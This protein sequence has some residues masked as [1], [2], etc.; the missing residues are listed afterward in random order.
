MFEVALNNS[1]A[2]FKVLA[3]IAEQ[4]E[5]R[6]SSKC[7][8]RERK[9]IIINEGLW[10]CFGWCQQPDT[11][12]DDEDYATKTCC[13]ASFDGAEKKEW[14][15]I[16]EK[17]SFAKDFNLL[18]KIR[19]MQKRDVKIDYYSKVHFNLNCVVCFFFN[20]WRSIWHFGWHVNYLMKM[21]LTLHVR[22]YRISLKTLSFGLEKRGQD[23][24]FLFFPFREIVSYFPQYFRVK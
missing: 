8:G 2:L 9:V 16:N 22:K 14:Y 3:G 20:F 23:F 12:D 1:E 21:K 15:Y 17:E 10:R 11:E 7:L 4:D 13:A 6:R 24:F 5:V 19:K 18:D